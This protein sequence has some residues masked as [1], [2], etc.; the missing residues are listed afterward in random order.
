MLTDD[1]AREAVLRAADELFY[2][3]GFQAVPMDAVRDKSGVPLKRMYALFPSKL[4]LIRAYLARQDDRW[5]D[6]VETY[7]TAR[8]DDPREQLLLVFDAMEARARHQVPFR[9]C[10]FHNAFGELGGGSPDAS[11]VVRAHKHHLRRFLTDTA[12]RAGLA[13]PAEIGLQLMLLAEGTLITAA[14][15]GDP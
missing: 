10:A 3:Q 1:E 13:R 9:G 7:V 15:D 5:R 4:D 11:T 14:I 8:S 6:G 2:T 12:R